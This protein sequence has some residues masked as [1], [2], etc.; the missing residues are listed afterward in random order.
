[1]TK[2]YEEMSTQG[3]PAHYTLDLDDI[4][5]FP[6]SNHVIANE[7][8]A[9]PVFRVKDKRGRV[10]FVAFYTSNPVIDAKGCGAG[11]I[12][13]VKDAFSHQFLDGKVGIR[14]EKTSDVEII[15]CSMSELWALNQQ[16]KERDDS[17]LLMN[18]A[19][20]DLPA[21]KTCAQCQTRY[22]TQDCLRA[23]RGSHKSKCKAISL[24]HQWNRTEW[25]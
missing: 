14:V 7:C 13:A 12:L 22:C 15:P 23:D 4:M 5:A 8:V 6:D 10:F 9:R 3:S 17:G 1:M 11:K 24:L 20:C 2:I 21:V 19:K 25:W 16:L 18:C